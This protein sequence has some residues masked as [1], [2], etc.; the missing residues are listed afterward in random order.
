VHVW[1]EELGGEGDRQAVGDKRADR[2]RIDGDRGHARREAG[3]VARA[4]E[5]AAAGGHRPPLVGEIGEADRAAPRE[6]MARR[7]ESAE[8]LGEEIVAA[9]ARRVAT[10]VRD[11][12][13]GEGRVQAAV[14]HGGFEVDHRAFGD[15]DLERGVALAQ[16][17][18][19]GGDDGGEGAREGADAQ[20]GALLGD[21]LRELLGG[22]REP[23]GDG[24]GVF[25]KEPAG[26]GRCA[27]AGAALEEAGAELAL[28]RG[29]LLGDR[30]L[31]EVQRVRG[32]G[33]RAVAGDLA[34]GEQAAWINDSLSLS[35]HKND[36][37]GLCAVARPSRHE[38][39][40]WNRSRRRSAP[41]PGG[42]G[43]GRPSPD[44]HPAREEARPARSDLGPLPVEG[45]GRRWSS[46]GW[47]AASGREGKADGL[48][49]WLDDA[50]RRGAA[51]SGRGPTGI[52]P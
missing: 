32:A 24:V 18:D 36:A 23:A 3:L 39:A 1:R 44:A 34:E 9:E 12:L 43:A 7:Q 50:W 15:L 35:D 37:C 21:E 45:C 31:A 8:W 38:P 19:G 42:R 30:G 40:C 25:E 28:E 47:Q 6:T 17:V 4:H 2:Q 51:A 52:G 29:D 27:A 14:L 10:L 48:G 20:E 46:R 33:E 5:H 22:E 49:E 16:D 26:G 11:V 13:E 41:R